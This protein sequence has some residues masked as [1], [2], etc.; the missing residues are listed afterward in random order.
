[1]RELA[2]LKAN[3][4]NIGRRLVS[5]YVWRAAF[6][7][8]Y[9]S[10]ANDLLYEDYNGLRACLETI[11]DSG[12]LDKTQ[13][14][15]IFDD[16]AYP[17]ADREL[18]ADVEQPAPWIGGGARLG[19]AL[20][21][22]QLAD[23]P[24]DWVVEKTKLNA[25]KV[26]ELDR[27]DSLDRHHVF[28]RKLLKGLF[29]PAQINHGL[30]G[31]LLCKPTNQSLSEKDPTE[32]LAWIREQPAG[33]TEEELRARVESH[34]VPY[35]AIVSEGDLAERYRRFIRERAKIVAKKIAERCRV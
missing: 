20:A 2:K 29:E 4:Q 22:I 10:R 31:V 27:D 25:F 1:M 33:P 19:K 3:P 5:A 21:A 26:R 6:S 35:D 11:G 15:P 13:L 18:L 32:Y 8:R 9:E 23:D 12:K 28:P 14:P 7:D 30:N 24:I 17:V 16:D 34:L